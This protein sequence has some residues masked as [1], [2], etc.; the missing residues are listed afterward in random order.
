MKFDAAVD[1]LVVALAEKQKQAREMKE[2]ANDS[3]G[4]GRFCKTEYI[5]IAQKVGEIQ[6]AIRRLKGGE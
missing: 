4:E 1:I 5:G 6:D 2:F 3:S